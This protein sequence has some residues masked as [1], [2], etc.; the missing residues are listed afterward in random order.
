ME[1][2]NS[3][4]ALMEHFYE[5]IAILRFFYYIFYNS[6]YIAFIFKTWMNEG[7]FQHMYIC[8]STLVYMVLGM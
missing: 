4:G 2:I 6:D 7:V 3:E 1:F 5:G 8:Y